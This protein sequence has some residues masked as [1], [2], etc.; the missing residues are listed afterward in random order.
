M[1]TNRKDEKQEQFL[2]ILAFL[3]WLLCVLF[4][5]A[6][7]ENWLD[8]A[9]AW[10][11][12]RDLSIP[13]LIQQMAYEGHPCFWHLL[14][15]PFAKLGF[16]YK[17][18]NGISIALV[19]A[20]AALMLRKS[21]IPLLLQA[22]SLFGCAFL[23]QM[24]VISRSYAL[25]PLFL[26][27]NAA[28][29]DKRHEM[30]CKY[31]LTLALL[32]QTHLYMVPMAGALSLLWLAE[33]L[34]RYWKQ[35]NR[36]LLRQAL[37]L[38]LPLISF[39][40]FLA[41]IKGSSKSS[42]FYFN[43]S[44]FRPSVLLNDVNIKLF[45][46]Y[47]GAPNTVNYYPQWLVGHPRL[48]FFT[49][50]FALYVPT[51]GILIYALYQQK[52]EMAK[53]VGVFLFAVTTQFVL[54]LLFVRTMLQK[55]AIFSFLSI[56]LLWICWPRLKAVIEKRLLVSSYLLLALFFIGV[57]NTAF[58]DINHDYSDSYAC[59]KYIEEN[60]PEDALL[61][62]F[63]E[64][65]GTPVIAYL[66]RDYFYDMET[67]RPASFVTWEDR[68]SVIRDYASLCDW[69]REIDPEAKEV[70]LLLWPM[71][72]TKYDNL[73]SHCDEEDLLYSGFEKDPQSIFDTSYLFRLRISPAA[74]DR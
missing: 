68:E 57:N 16:P 70:Y 69:I 33:A 42:A 22:A 64:D 40:L 34:S 47:V 74:V 66:E 49:V 35:D 28:S 15:M 1:G 50:L 39:L 46:N 10:R 48:V 29:Y 17:T 56:W 51:T 38:S 13:A 61:F 36:M 58:F 19:A 8:E 31:G 71:D 72:N 60:L 59:A 23:Y 24:P 14:L 26:F 63:S 37:G 20:A 6:R 54:S 53:P 5:N 55:T 11:L 3:L 52:I 73:L 12:A 43:F 4:L 32:V 45:L 65:A 25:I 30:P 41:Q 44:L 18:M 27:L 9:Q 67:R 62:S 21:S 2:R 7:H